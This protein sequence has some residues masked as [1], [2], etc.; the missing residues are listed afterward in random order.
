LSSALKA[1]TPDWFRDQRLGFGTGAVDSH[2]FSPASQH[3]S[4]GSSWHISPLNVTVRLSSTR[5][6]H[7]KIRGRYLRPKMQKT[8]RAAAKRGVVLNAI[9]GLPLMSGFYRLDPSDPQIWRAKA[10]GWCC[11]FG[12][13]LGHCS[14]V[15]ES[16]ASSSWDGV[17]STRNRESLE[18][19]F[20]VG[21]QYLARIRLLASASPAA[22]LFMQ[23]C[24]SRDGSVRIKTMSKIE[25]IAVTLQKICN[26]VTELSPV[27]RTGVEISSR[28]RSSGGSACDRQAS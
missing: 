9:C 22:L 25:I 28:R 23:K 12:N 26:V 17:F 1:S 6:R 16:P 2:H 4:S 10:S 3:V 7:R 21:S 5:G 13:D 14:M 15:L 20:P 27:K 11:F 18:S 8:R 19:G 24:Q